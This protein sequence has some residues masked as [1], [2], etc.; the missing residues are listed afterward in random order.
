MLK[1][2]L[3]I[4]CF[5]S[6]I[7]ADAQTKKFEEE[8]ENFF[9]G[10][11]KVGVNGTKIAGS[12]FSEGF[13]Y[14][15]QLGVFFQFNYSKR[16]GIQP[17]FSLV[18][19]SSEFTNDGTAIYDDIFGNGSQQKASFCYLE[20]PVLMNMN[21]GPTKRVKLQLGPVY[22]GLLK[23]EVNSTDL[24]NFY[25]KTEWSL[26]GGFWIQLPLFHFGARYKMGFTN[27]NGADPTQSWKNR[28]IQAFVGLTF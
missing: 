10:G 26:L 6:F 9:R 11:V 4:F 2:L 15:F 27:V 23:Q 7:S 24:Q 22:N 17:E 5:F 19:G 28:S 13:N 20:I 12:S 1:K 3:F 8:T 18:Q 25:K 14:N 16:F 21:I